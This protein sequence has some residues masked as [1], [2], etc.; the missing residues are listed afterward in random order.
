MANF[1]VQNCKKDTTG[2]L[3]L[4]NPGKFNYFRQKQPLTDKEGMLMKKQ[5]LITTF[6]MLFSG[7]F[8]WNLLHANT[9]PLHSEVIKLK[10]QG[11]KVTETHSNVEARPGIKPYQNL[12]RVV[13][14]VKYRL[15]KGTEVLFCVVEYDS[16]WD[17]IRESC[18][19]SLQQAEE[20][21]RK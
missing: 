6:C 18:A 12:E 16:Q 11:W 8:N 3:R 2:T 10:R 4:I 15:N 17:T 13:Q 5:L 14:V 21:L 19:D 7:L 9:S 1:Y 20:Q